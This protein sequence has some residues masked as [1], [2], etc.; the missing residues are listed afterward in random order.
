MSLIEDDNDRDRSIHI[1][2]DPGDEEPHSPVEEFVYEV[3]GEARP[4]DAA[5]EVEETKK[6]RKEKSKPAPLS[7][8]SISGSSGSL[9]N[10]IPVSQEML[11]LGALPV[12][13]FMKDDQLGCIY[14]CHP[15]YD[16]AK[17]GVT[18]Q[19]IG[20]DLD[21]CLITTRSGRTFPSDFVNDWK[22]WDGQVATKLK[23]LYKAGAY[24]C[25]VSNQSTIAKPNFGEWTQVE[26]KI[27]N[28]VKEIGVPMDF[29]CCYS[30][31]SLFRKPNV[32]GW[33]MMQ[34]YRCP[35]AVQGESAYVGDAA[36][37]RALGSWRADFAD[38]DYKLAL[39]LGVNFYTPER[40]FLDDRS[41]LHNHLPVPS[42]Y[43]K[44]S[45]SGGNKSLSSDEF[46]NVMRP[47]KVLAGGKEIVL[48]VAPAGCGKTTMAK[49]IQTRSR[50]EDE[51][52]IVNQDQMKDRPRCIRAATN[53]IQVKRANIIVDNTNLDPQVRTE[54]VN[55]ANDHGYLIR[56]V[57]LL[58]DKEVAKTLLDYRFLATET[59]H[60]ERRK[61]PP[62]ALNAH[63][64]R[65]FEPDA[66]NE[67]FYQVDKLDWHPVYPATDI[68]RFLF[69]I[70][71]R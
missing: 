15:G 66:T 5:G 12:D 16:E 9:W 8:S 34:M 52:V 43:T 36:G 41:E 27:R 57:Y 63:Y 46:A 26:T 11:R 33:Q 24:L 58:T 6:L 40:F 69:E 3:P 45:L 7:S 22:L 48:M 31:P 42:M 17:I 56:C 64:N 68:D 71:L 10:T 14:W 51:Y 70:Y 53:A 38:T 55:L 29:V 65:I 50:V 54:W 18:T 32:G 67:G 62:Q 60:E 61:I 19:M 35:N 47:S 23:E 44:L 49:M 1:G 25:I 2:C 39:N 37:R 13:N 4:A 20:F 59:P 30:Q 28:I 21:H